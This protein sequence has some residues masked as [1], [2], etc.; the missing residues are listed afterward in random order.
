MS[1][2]DRSIGAPPPAVG[3]RLAWEGLPAEIRDATTRWLGSELADPQWG[4]YLE[5]RD[6]LRSNSAAREVYCAAKVRLA[7]R[8]AR[9][10]RKYTEAKDAVVRA[11]L[12]QADRPAS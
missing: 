6:L 5:F 3:Q 8:H 2:D 1:A 4:A 10:R 11:L 9:E 7:Q 12:D